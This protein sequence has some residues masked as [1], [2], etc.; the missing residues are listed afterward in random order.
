MASI[1]QVQHPVASQ[2]TTLRED[3]APAK[4]VSQ[5]TPTDA[6]KVLGPVGTA[7][8]RSDT[9]PGACAVGAVDAGAGVGGQVA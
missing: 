7:Q 8:L 6:P 1:A 3:M 4:R 2:G 9:G 5:D